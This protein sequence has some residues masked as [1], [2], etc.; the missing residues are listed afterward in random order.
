MVCDTLVSVDD[1]PTST[2][3]TVSS[4]VSSFALPFVR[5][6]FSSSTTCTTSPN[7]NSNNND[8]N[9]KNDTPN[10]TKQ[11][12]RPMPDMYVFDRHD[13]DIYGSGSATIHGTVMTTTATTRAARPRTLSNKLLTC[14][15]PTPM[16]TP[17]WVKFCFFS[18]TKVL[19]TCSPKTLDRRTLLENYLLEDDDDDDDDDGCW[20]S[21][22]SIDDTFSTDSPH[23]LDL[24][25]NDHCNQPGGKSSFHHGQEQPGPPQ[26]SVVVKTTIDPVVSMMTSFDILSDLGKGR[27]AQV[28]K[29]RSKTNGKLYAV[30][31]NLEMFANEKDRE[32]QLAEFR[33]MQHL[34]SVDYTYN[35]KSNS[36]NNNGLYLVSFYQAWQ[37]EGHLHCQ[38]ELCC[39]HSCR[40]L[41]DS[42]RRR[43]KYPCLRRL[44][45]AADNDSNPEDDDD[46]DADTIG[47]HM[48][49]STIW[50]IC[51]DVCAG[52]SHMH[53]HGIVHH[54]V[55]PSN[56]FSFH[57]V[58]L[59]PC[60]RLGILAWRGRLER[61]WRTG[62]K[63]TPNTW[64]PS[65]CHVQH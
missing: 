30:K 54:D 24:K 21:P 32:R 8:S 48:P 42:M 44:I 56:V 40:E 41:M 12:G 58:V 38:M 39:R 34:Q 33:Y 10:T 35:N 53:S 31:K 1:H 2:M 43:A 28:F 23:C 18:D 57:K 51:H 64:L 11:Q 14:C 45:A 27:F 65:S 61:H 5:M 62:K 3:E 37:Q 60:A 16:P 9:N 19:A 59:G 26:L 52:L 36:N 29:V 46:D 20:S 6:L 63:V 25:S 50:K 4:T 55:K 13:D 22:M 47:R 17:S 49:E 7:N 15:P